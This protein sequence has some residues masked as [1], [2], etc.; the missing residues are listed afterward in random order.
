M[1]FIATDPPPADPVKAMVRE[2]YVGL[3]GRDADPG[4]QTFWANLLKAGVMTPRDFVWA[5]TQS[6]EGQWLHGGQTDEQFVNSVYMNALGRPAE[7]SA[8]SAWA[9]VMRA[10]AI[11]GDVLSAISTPLEGQMHFAAM[12]G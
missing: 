7:L 8:Q 9:G 5:L 11:Q 2:D 3:F 1:G 10:G 6:P 4:A 12:H